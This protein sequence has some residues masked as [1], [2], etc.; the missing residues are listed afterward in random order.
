MVKNLFVSSSQVD[1]LKI[2]KISAFSLK[3][4]QINYLR[5]VHSFFNEIL[6]K[7]QIIIASFLLSEKQNGLSDIQLL[8][9]LELTRKLQKIKVLKL[10]VFSLGA[11]QKQTIYFTETLF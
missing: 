10:L 5:L 11:S 7:K 8:C 9:R 4:R 2:L 1:I 6:D 3:S